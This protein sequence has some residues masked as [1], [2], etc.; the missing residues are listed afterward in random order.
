MLWLLIILNFLI[1]T[2]DAYASGAIWGQARNTL[3]KAL[4]VVIFVL[5]Y[6]GFLYTIVLVGIVI[7]YLPEVWLLGANVFLGGPIILTGIVITIHGWIQ[8]IR[9]RS[10]LG[11]AVSIWNTFATFHNIGV[12]IKSFR[13]LKDIGGIK[14]L[15][16]AADEGKGKTKVALFLLVAVIITTLFIYGMFKVGVRSTASL[17]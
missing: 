16:N 8:A 3:D 17:R 2:W 4:A 12:W 6:T 10:L 11:G 15:I 9:T 1:C 13:A 7:G 5:A 14:G